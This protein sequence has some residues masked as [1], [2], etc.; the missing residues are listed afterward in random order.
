MSDFGVA[1]VINKMV[2]VWGGDGFFYSPS[3][4]RTERMSSERARGIANF[5]WNGAANSK[6]DHRFC[7][8]MGMNVGKFRRVVE[9]V[10]RSK[11]TVTFLP[12]EN[13]VGV[14]NFTTGE[15]VNVEG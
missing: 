4:E 12:N 14:Y 2:L 15:F 3:S 8:L 10:D 11:A 6:T 13:A 1:V 7:V 9:I 5:W